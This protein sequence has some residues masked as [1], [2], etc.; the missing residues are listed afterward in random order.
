MAALQRDVAASQQKPP[1]G[2]VA[3][4]LMESPPGVVAWS[5]AALRLNAAARLA[6][7]A[8]LPVFRALPAAHCRSG[9]PRSRHL[10]GGDGGGACWPFVVLSTPMAAG[11]LVRH[12]PSAL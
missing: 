3:R 8:L 10:Y 5:V 6:H 1:M 2:A 12:H 4:V 7:P 9:S 11:L